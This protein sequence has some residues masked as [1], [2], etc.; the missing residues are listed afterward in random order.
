M[1]KYLFVLCIVPLI[2]YGC[3]VGRTTEVRGYENESYLQ[4][5]QGQQ[6]YQEGVEVYVDDLPFFVAKVNK[7]NDRTVKGNVY[8]V[9]S[10]TRHLKVVYKG[11]VLFDKQVI[12]S[13][14]QT[15]Q[16]QLP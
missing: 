12:L 6:K 2:L 5:V 7:V 9:K 11:K 8:T 1:K 13:S 15:R 16:I 3:R 10:G 4:F 14:Q